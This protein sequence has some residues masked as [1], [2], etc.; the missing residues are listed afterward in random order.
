MNRPFQKGDKVQIMA[1]GRTM[2]V[3]DVGPILEE[4]M[5]TCTWKAGSKQDWNRFLPG[6]LKLIES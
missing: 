1:G 3:T 4:L 6:D 5:V 2:T